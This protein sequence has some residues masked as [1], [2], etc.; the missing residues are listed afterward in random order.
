M[1]MALHKDFIPEVV[2]KIPHNIDRLHHYMIDCREDENSLDLQKRYRDVRY[3][4]LNSSRRK[5]FRGIRRIGH[6]KGNYTCL[7]DECSYYLEKHQRNQHQFKSNGGSKFCFSC[8]CLA[9]KIKCGAIK[10]IEFDQQ[11]KM[12]QVYHQGKRQCHVKPSIY[13]NDDDIN[14]ALQETGCS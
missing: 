12:L 13:Q 5:G 2:D 10:L 8:D 11:K 4:H 9:S 6:C 7:N 3:F 14:Q 1:D